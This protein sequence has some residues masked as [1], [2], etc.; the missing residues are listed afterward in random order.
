MA[1]AAARNAENRRVVAV[2]G[3]GA[4]TA[5]VAFE[6]LKHAGSLPADLLAI[7]NDND[8]SIS[9]ERRGALESLRAR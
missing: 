2:S 5:G 8:M 6:A 1:V 4:L 9:R 3:D 7:L